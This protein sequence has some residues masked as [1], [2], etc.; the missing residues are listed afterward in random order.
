MLRHLLTAALALTLL[1]ACSGESDD[2]PSSEETTMYCELID[3][4]SLRDLTSESVRAYGGPA[5]AKNEYRRVDCDLYERESGDVVLLTTQSEFS[6]AE[7][8]DA[9]RA[10]IEAEKARYAV[11]AADSFVEL[12]EGGLSGYAWYDPT[13]ATAFAH[14]MTS[15]RAVLLSAPAAEG[16]AGTVPDLLLTLAQE[17][18]TNLDAWDAENPS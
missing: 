11:E 4:A 10:Q 18:E 3:P 7:Q 16:K 12:D 9:E 1:A 5:Q 13:K 2:D 14:L 6:S 15:S 8:A 17:I